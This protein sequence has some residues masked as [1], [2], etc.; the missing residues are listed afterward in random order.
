ME[1]FTNYFRL[2]ATAEDCLHRDLIR[3][4]HDCWSPAAPFSLHRLVWLSGQQPGTW[5]GPG[6]MCATLVKAVASAKDQFDVLSHIH[7]YY[8][9]D[10]VIYRR[11]IMELARGHPVTRKLN[12]FHFTNHTGNYASGSMCDVNQHD[13][14]PDTLTT[15][16]NVQDPSSSVVQCSTQNAII[17]LIPLML[18]TSKHIDRM[19]ITMICGLFTDPCCI[20]LIGGRPKHSLYVAGS[21]A[22]ELVYL[23]PHYTQPVVSDVSRVDFCVKVSVIA[24]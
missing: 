14:L 5:F 17:I 19:F 22:R 3:W 24:A 20:G 10:R 8:A 7:V 15:T 6:S 13:I 1:T 21:V 23:D 11:E 4:F 9:R 12:R 16:G 2:I 18:G